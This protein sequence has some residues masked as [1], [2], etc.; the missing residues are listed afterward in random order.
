MTEPTPHATH[1]TP[2]APHDTH[3][4][5][6]DTHR[7]TYAQELLGLVETLLPGTVLQP[8]FLVR[9]AYRVS[10]A[11]DERVLRRALDDVVARHGALRTL[12]LRDGDDLRQRVLPPMP[13]RLAVTRLGPGRSFDAWISEVALRP[14]PYDEPPLLW[15]DLGRKGDDAVLVL[16]VHHVAADA[17]SQDV[18]AR[19]VVAAYT[20]RL[21]GEP[22]LAPDVMQY[23]DIAADDHS[24]K[25]QARIG[26]ALPY[27]RERL[28]GVEGLG[29]PA[30]TPDAAPGPTAVHSFRID[31][32]L[33]DAVRST[34]RRGRTTP[35]TV[36]LTAFVGAL[37]PPGD[38][39]VP[40]ITA[41]RIPSEWDT[42][43][44]L[45][46][47]LQIRVEHSGAHDAEALRELGPRVDRR[48][49]EAYA[50]DI[51]LIRVLEQSPQLLE[52]MTA[53]DLVAPVFQMIVR[54]PV[55]PAT[56][57]PAL[58]LDRLALDAQ[59]AMPM[60]VPFLWTMRWDGDPGGYITYDTH[61]F[62]AAWMER[63]V[64]TYLDALTGLV[65]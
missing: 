18:L 17:W 60:P 5:T 27:W 58:H 56:G 23:A 36:L 53:R 59:T 16:V 11:V 48:C 14:H 43:G 57:T 45:L 6:H 38:A 33:R 25:W 49:R 3:H 52:R 61:L 28:T 30:E 42:V 51:P 44:F 62:S 37:L 1:D 15:A 24:D 63:A 19:D 2:R 13:S 40:V 21:H 65:G 26:Q 39:L 50:N 54:S 9:A 64:A 35:F 8:G 10:G 47:L 29:L 32:E 46:N 4:A 7:A 22:P 34:A 12:L 55:R 20:A 31:D 41:G